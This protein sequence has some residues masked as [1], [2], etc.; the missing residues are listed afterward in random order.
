M[1]LIIL[2]NMKN[3]RTSLN[4]QPMKKFRG[5]IVIKIREKG[6]LNEEVGI[7]LNFLKKTFM[8]FAWVKGN[9]KIW[10]KI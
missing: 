1:L 10:K 4:T 7:V 6:T 2:K 9:P 3:K 8:L 5:R